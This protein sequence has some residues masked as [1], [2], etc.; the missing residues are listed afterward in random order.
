MI[1]VKEED[2]SN[3]QLADASLW[4]RGYLV[5]TIDNQYY[6]VVAHDREGNRY[7][8]MNGTLHDFDLK[9]KVTKVARKLEL[10]PE[11]I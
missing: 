7:M 11:W 9:L 10:T 3:Y 5:K 1:N 6:L 2:A 4:R 8:S